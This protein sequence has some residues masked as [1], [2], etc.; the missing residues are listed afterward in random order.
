MI[1]SA[2]SFKRSLEKIEL[3]LSGSTICFAYRVKQIICIKSIMINL[4]MFRVCLRFAQV[5]VYCFYWLLDEGDS[6]LIFILS[7]CFLRLPITPSYWQDLDV[8]FIL[9]FVTTLS[10]FFEDF[11]S[12]LTLFIV[13]YKVYLATT[14]L[15]NAR[16]SSAV[17]MCL[18][19]YL[20]WF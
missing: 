9:S 15:S 17:R 13:T 19:A 1:I 16:Q 18:L 20:Y 4:C 5:T 2:V 7:F 12:L 6:L 14:C 8:F 10:F 3:T 11:V